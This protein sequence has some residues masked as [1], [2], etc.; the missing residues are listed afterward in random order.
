LS[1]P[2]A[3]RFD[4]I[5]AGD[6]FVVA[7]VSTERSRTQEGN[8]DERLVLRCARGSDSN[9]SATAPLHVVEGAPPEQP[10]PCLARF[11]GRLHLA[12]AVNELSSQASTAGG[13]EATTFT[14]RA[15]I[16]YF[17]SLDGGS[18]W[19]GPR[20]VLAAA[21]SG[22]TS[23]PSRF[24]QIADL[25]L[26]ALSNG[27]HLFFNC[28]GLHQAHSSDGLSW[29][30]PRALAPHK[31]SISGTHQS[32]SVS[33]VESSGR[34]R[35]FW[36]DERFQASDRTL[37]NPLGGFP[38]SDAP[39]WANNDVFSLRLSPLLHDAGGSG[40]PKLERLTQPLSYARKVVGCMDREGI[41]VAWAGRARVG[42]EEESA[43][44]NPQIFVTL[45]DSN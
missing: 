27:V 30:P 6:D 22:S 16:L 36:V 4:A 40:L 23:G 3:L 21:Q 35:L 28:F 44:E 19:A 45:L 25:K 14:S 42:K 31:A 26:L 7:W 20:S 38:W 43:E 9:P 29:G 24:S 39:Q 15:E 37:T 18:T 10:A 41:V 34:G 2:R 1:A 32:F 8:I 17:H 12:W 33:V 13:R 5:A 11:G